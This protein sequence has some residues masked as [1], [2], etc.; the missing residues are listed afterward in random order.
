MRA[1]LTYLLGTLS[2]ENRFWDVQPLRFSRYYDISRSKP[3]KKSSFRL[4]ASAENVKLRVLKLSQINL[5]WKLWMARTYT[6]F[7]NKLGSNVTIVET[8]KHNTI[9]WSCFEVK[10]N[11]G[12]KETDII[13]F[14]TTFLDVF[15]KFVNR[16][17]YRENRSWRVYNVTMFDVPRDSDNV[18]VNR[19]ASIVFHQYFFRRR[20]YAWT[21]FYF[22]IRR[23]LKCVSCRPTG[24][25]IV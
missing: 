23:A 19:N 9:V 15:S 3:V 14:I 20:A 11:C 12:N 21:L 16:K 22:L 17:I 7:V 13:R 4:W 5:T 8:G 24:N 1:R 10:R 25:T 6:F 18:Y 2:G